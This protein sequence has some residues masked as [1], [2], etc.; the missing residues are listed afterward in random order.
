MK[1]HTPGRWK[2]PG[3]NVFRVIA[4]DHN[5]VPLRCI[6]SDT[7]PRDVHFGKHSIG[8]DGYDCNGE[9]AAANARLIAAAPDLLVVAKMVAKLFEGTDAPL[10][11]R[12]RAAIAKAT[13]EREGDEG[14]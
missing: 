12:A 1:N 2:V 3:A 5:D 14:G 11:Y 9:E 10:G 7:A 8:W 13:G 6:V 4:V